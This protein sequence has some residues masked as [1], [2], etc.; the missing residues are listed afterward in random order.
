MTWMRI[1]RTIASVAAVALLA[2]SLAACSKKKAHPVARRDSG[3]KAEESTP[4]VN[5]PAH[6][7]GKNTPPGDWR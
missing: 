7:T 3:T 2:T 5:D 4:K 6:E 1:A